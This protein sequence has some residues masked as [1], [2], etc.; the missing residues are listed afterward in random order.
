[1]VLR[2]PRWFIFSNTCFLTHPHTFQTPFD[3]RFYE[4][5]ITAG[6]E[7]P[8]KPP[9]VRFVSRVN[10]QFV[11]Q[12]TGMVEQQLPQLA[13]WNRNMKLLDIVLGLKNSMTNA[14]N[15]RLPQPPDGSSF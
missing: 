6:P 14:H 2:S 7:Y 13:G 3:Q 9:V 5:R 10:L 8:L 1:M 11:N 15:R 4:I 12:G